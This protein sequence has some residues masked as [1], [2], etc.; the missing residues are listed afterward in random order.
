MKT[1]L[2]RVWKSAPLGI[3]AAALA[4]GGAGALAQQSPG[5]TDTEIRIG[6]YLPL[7]GPW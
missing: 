5:V 2:Q 4:P 3:A 6:A 1:Y 7:T